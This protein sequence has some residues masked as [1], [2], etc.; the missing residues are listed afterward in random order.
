MALWD[1]DPPGTKRVI[2]T[3]YKRD[4]DQLLDLPSF[5][6]PEDISC[7]NRNVDLSHLDYLF[8]YK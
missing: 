4:K 7:R 3:L 1:K 2:I 6:R 5:R 8:N